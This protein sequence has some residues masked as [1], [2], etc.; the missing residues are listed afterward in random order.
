MRCVL[1]VEEEFIG[2]EGEDGVDSK[3]ESTLIGFN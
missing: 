2:R 1:E 3:P